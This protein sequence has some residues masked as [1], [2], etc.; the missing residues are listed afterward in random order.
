MPHLTSSALACRNANAC[1]SCTPEALQNGK[2][3]CT[4]VLQPGPATFY[5]AAT[6]CVLACSHAKLAAALH[7]PVHMSALPAGDRQYFD[8]LSYVA[9]KALARQLPPR[10]PQPSAEQQM[11]DQM[12]GDLMLPSPQPADA[13]ADVIAA[14]HLRMGQQILKRVAASATY[15][16]RQLLASSSP[17]LDVVRPGVRLILEFFCDQGE[18][19][20]HPCWPPGLC[21]LKQTPNLSVVCQMSTWCKQP[22]L[23]HANMV[24][25]CIFFRLR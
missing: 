14:L 12:H 21:H 22:L 13:R 6:T 9:F 3:H 24:Q 7:L 5:L 2:C 8:L 11:L 25:L 4:L 19:C 10:L 15:P 18:V 17:E 23:S 1:G 16:E 20:L